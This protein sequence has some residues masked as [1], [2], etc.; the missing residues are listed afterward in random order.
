MAYSAL[1]IPERALDTIANDLLACNAKLIAIDGR[2]AAGKTAAAKALAAR[3]NC[4]RL[5]L[6]DYLEPGTRQFVASLRFDALRRALDGHRGRIV[7][8]GICLLN[9]LRQLQ[10]V[11]EYL[12]YVDTPAAQ[13][14]G[15]LSSLLGNELSEYELGYRPQE[16]AD[17]I[18]RIRGPAMTQSQGNVELAYLKMRTVFASLLVVAGIVQ[19]VI[20]ALLLNAGLNSPGNTSVKIMGA[21]LSSTSFGATI[22]CTAVLWGLLAYLSRPQFSSRSEVR[23]VRNADGSSDE[24]EFRSSTQLRAAD[25]KQPGR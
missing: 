18:I 10:L 14:E 23:S 19:A 25:R 2:L 8:E 24:Y 1:H 7:I 9:V 12:V 16:I 21:E 4:A 17:R 5:H 22:L 6:D 11:P 15:R 13:P 20:G 3:L